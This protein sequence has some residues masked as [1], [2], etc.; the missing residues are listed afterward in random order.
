MSDAPL[1]GRRLLVDGLDFGEGARWHDGRLWYSDFYRQ[2]V[3]ALR[4]GGEPEVVLQLDDDRP[5]GL[6]WLPDGRLLVVAMQSRQV[7]RLDDDGVLRL[8]GDISRIA[9][10]DANDMIV[11]R[12]GFAYVGNFGFDILH[13][14]ER[15][16]AHL[17]LVRP[18]GSVERVARDLAF[19]NG[20]AVLPDG[21]TLLVGESSGERVTAF[22]IGGD[23]TLT[24]RRMWADLPGIS[25]DGCSVV[26][27]EGGIWFA[28]AR[29][30]RVVRVEAGGRVTDAIDME[31]GTYACALGGDDGR[32]LF[33]L[34]CGATGPERCTGRGLGRVWELRVARRAHPG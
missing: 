31:Q 9:T 29:N 10:F 30:R 26:D 2:Q 17:A 15:C 13:G 20:S 23:G 28:D 16:L 5:S 4:P 25:P 33:V 12:Q 34:T 22:T 27:V 8:H 6:G 18:D 19:P 3:C 11:T 21:V 32:S 14:G 1:D 24:G 7:R